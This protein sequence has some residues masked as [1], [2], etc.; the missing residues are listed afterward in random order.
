MLRLVQKIKDTLTEI[1]DGSF[2]I[3]DYETEM[4]KIS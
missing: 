3:E 4:L 1:N 2:K